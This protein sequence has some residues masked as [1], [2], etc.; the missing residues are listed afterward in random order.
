LGRKLPGEPLQRFSLLETL[1]ELVEK[2]GA[3]WVW[4]HRERLL[5]EAQ[6]IIDEGMV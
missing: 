3:E 1:S 6:F 4:E 5:H 2:K